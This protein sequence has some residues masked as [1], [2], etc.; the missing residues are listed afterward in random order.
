MQLVAQD[1]QQLNYLNKYLQKLTVLLHFILSLGGCGPNTQTIEDPQKHRYSLLPITSYK[2]LRCRVQNSHLNTLS[3]PS[4]SDETFLQNKLQKE[5]LKSSQL[6]KLFLQLQTATSSAQHI[7][8]KK[9]HR[10]ARTRKANKRKHYSSSSNS[11]ET[12]NAS[13]DSESSS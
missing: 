9:H 5:C 7:K 4:T 3:M 8:L 11:S 10:R 1:H 2:Q 13:S 12:S 6:K